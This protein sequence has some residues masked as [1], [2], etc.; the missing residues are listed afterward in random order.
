MS[1]CWE[2]FHEVPLILLFLSLTYCHACVLMKW[3][4][5]YLFWVF[6]ILLTVSCRFFYSIDGE[7]NHDYWNST[8]WQR[9]FFICVLLCMFVY[10]HTFIAQRRQEDILKLTKFMKI[11]H[12]MLFLVKVKEITSARWYF[13]CSLCV[14]SQRFYFE[15]FKY[16][17]HK[18]TLE[19]LN[20][21]FI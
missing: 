12:L 7:L 20:L 4:D 15:S 19:E 11:N 1:E 8:Y 16:C 17:K 10:C 3:S 5:M 13:H 18:Y 6:W 14:Y 2:I 9:L 21:V